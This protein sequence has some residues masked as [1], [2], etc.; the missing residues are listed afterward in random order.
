MTTS[1]SHRRRYWR[2]LAAI[3]VV[4]IGLIGGGLWVDDY[5]ARK[6]WTDACAEADRLDPGWRWDDLMAA[7]PI[8]PGDSVGV[9]VG[10]IRRAFPQRWPDWPTLL[11]DDD[12]PAPPP[13]PPALGSDIPPAP[14]LQ[15]SQ[16]PEDRRREF[17]EA[18]ENSLS[19]PNPG[20]QLTSGHAAAV[21]LALSAATEGLKRVDGLEDLPTGRLNRSHAATV[22]ADVFPGHLGDARSVAKMLQLRA[23]VAAREGE[24]DVALL[25][26]H[27]ILA[28]SRFAGAEPSFLSELV[29]LAIRSICLVT[30]EHVLARGEPSHESLTRLQQAIW[31]DLDDTVILSALRGERAY[32]VDTIRALDDGRLSYDDLHLMESVPKVTGIDKVDKWLRRWRGGGTWTKPGTAAVVHY[33]TF[34]IEIAKESPDALRSRAGEIAA[35]RSCMSELAQNETATYDQYIKAEWRSRA[36]LSSAAIALAAE[37]YRRDHNN[38]PESLAELVA[39]R[40]LAAVPLDPFDG[41]PL[42]M[43]RLPDG[44]VI[45]SVG[46][47]LSDDG[48]EVRVDPKVGRQP[49]DV[50]VRLWDVLKRRQAPNSR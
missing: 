35:Y 6:A 15:P 3:V 28:I 12:L 47:D 45:Y 17:G 24:V 1:P 19:D 11:S 20:R 48:G 30:L 9:R 10:E 37:R 39:V 7:R 42:R 2:W 32:T 50:G 4:G 41:Q 13:P 49:K 33:Q 22:F 38:W 26:L 27:R 34:L 16:L 31:A 25:D 8:P 5:S 18:A 14:E 21:R 44:L 46:Q 29:Q 43:R 36:L 23:E 40:L